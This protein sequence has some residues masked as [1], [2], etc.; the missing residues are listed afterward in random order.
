[1]TPI[2]PKEEGLKKYLLYIKDGIFII[3]ILISLAGW[4]ST[5]SKNEAILETTIRYNTEV[6]KK[7]EIFMDKQIE[8]NGKQAEL[9]GKYSQFI[10]SHKE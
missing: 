5:K 2:K 4:I 8:L 1:M 10:A 9:N 7:L 3:G 6:V